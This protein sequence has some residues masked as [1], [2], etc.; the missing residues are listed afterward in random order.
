VSEVKAWRNRGT[1][2]A[3]RCGSVVA[4]A[5]PS[6]EWKCSSTPS[7]SAC[8]IGNVSGLQEAGAGGRICAREAR[9]GHYFR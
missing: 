6:W 3:T 9:W 5:G 2:L 7:T 1:N 8:S 4:F